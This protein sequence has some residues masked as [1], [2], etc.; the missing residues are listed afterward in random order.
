MSENE[1]S[2][3]SAELIDHLCR[4]SPLTA[5]EA[6]HLVA[7]VLAYFSQVPDEYL[8]TRHQELQAQGFSNSAIFSTLQREML[9]RRFAAKPLTT[10]QI[11]RAIYG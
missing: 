9:D 7:E 5:R 11:R 3:A 10:R 8:R 1:V 2:V 4:I 6:E